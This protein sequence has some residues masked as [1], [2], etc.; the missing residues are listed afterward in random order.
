L[1]PQQ[2]YQETARR[3][4]LSSL[5]GAVTAAAALF[6]GTTGE[7]SKL[8]LQG[9][10]PVARAEKTRSFVLKKRWSNK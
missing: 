5:A 4:R 9:L 8:A 3:T 7:L 6:P 2:P 1:Q 10:P